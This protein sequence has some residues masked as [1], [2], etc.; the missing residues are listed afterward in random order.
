MVIELGL[1]NKCR[2][3]NIGLISSVVAR[4]QEVFVVCVLAR[5]EWTKKRIKSKVL[6]QD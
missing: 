4:I 5:E 3:A 6:N 2:G 1:V